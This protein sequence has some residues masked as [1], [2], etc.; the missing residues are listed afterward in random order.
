MSL[1]SNIKKYR[2]IKGL[3]Q[4]ELGNLLNKSKGVISKWEKG[5]NKPDADTMGKLCDILNITPNDL[6]DWKNNNQTSLTPPPHTDPII[7]AAAG[8]GLTNADERMREILNAKQSLCD[9]IYAAN[10]D[11]RQIKELIALVKT[12]EKL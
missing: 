10:L 1:S 5:E 12:F 9:T 11:K 7:I 3:T 4:D 8:G 6:F 2:E